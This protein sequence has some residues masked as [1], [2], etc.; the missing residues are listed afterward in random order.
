MPHQPVPV[1]SVFAMDIMHLS[2]LNDPDLLLKLFTGK[3]DV[4]EPDTRDD[5]D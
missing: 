1:P 2:V 5:W 4:C 3:L